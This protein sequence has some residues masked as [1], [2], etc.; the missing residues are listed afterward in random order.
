MTLQGHPRSLILAPIKSAYENS[1]NWSSVVTLVLSRPVSVL[2]ELLY[3][4]SHFFHTPPLFR[5]KFRDVAFSVDRDVRVCR[6][7]TP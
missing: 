3:A 1:Y 4:K 6:E 5:P 7:R 2:L